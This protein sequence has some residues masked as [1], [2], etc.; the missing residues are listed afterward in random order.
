MQR[1]PS[2]G[3]FFQC[4][5]N[6]KN[7]LVVLKSFR[8]IYPDSSFIIHNDGGLDY[9]HIANT[10]NAAYMY[11]ERTTSET[12]VSLANIGRD[13]VLQYLRNLWVSA[14]LIKE[15]YILILEDDVRLCR[16]IISAL[17]F[18]LNG[19]NPNEPFDP[20]LYRQLPPETPNFYGGCGGSIL[21]RAFITW[22][23]F[24]YVEMLVN[25]LSLETYSSDMI[26]SFV[27]RM[28]GGT[29]GQYDDFAECWYPDVQERYASGRV[30]VLHQYKFDYNVPL[31]KEEEEEIWPPAAAAAA[32]AP[33][34]KIESPCPPNANVVPLNEYN[35]DSRICQHE[36]C[37]YAGAAEERKVSPSV[38]REDR[39]RD[40]GGMEGELAHGDHLSRDGSTGGSAAAAA[41]AAVQADPNLLFSVRNRH[42][43]S[44]GRAGAVL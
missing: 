4:Y 9:S 17:P 43:A 38:S 18:I 34:E 12:N 39:V 6:P 35:G 11:H 3:G 23:P 28:F 19:C 41:A 15:D 42:P 29:V 8:A 20:E 36:A 16:T 37:G 5:K 30:A 14:E 25:S 2:I 44:A 10:Y 31:T 7:F 27:V 40:G 24:S 22:I 32:A 1:F 33:H 26:L 21:L 13:R